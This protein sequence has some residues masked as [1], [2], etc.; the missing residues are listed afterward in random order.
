V[1]NPGLEV[2]SCGNAILLNPPNNRTAMLRYYHYC[3]CCCCAAVVLYRG[4]PTYEQVAF[5][6]SVRKSFVR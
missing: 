2:R 4:S 5:Q 6:I 3:C 1:K